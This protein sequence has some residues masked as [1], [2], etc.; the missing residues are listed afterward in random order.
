MHVGRAVKSVAV[1]KGIAMKTLAE[2]VG[3]KRNSLS[4]KLAREK[5]MTSDLEK[6]AEAM[7]VTVSH[8]ILVAEQV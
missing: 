4:V 7:G 1:S 3:L 6:V 8:I 2:R 5:W